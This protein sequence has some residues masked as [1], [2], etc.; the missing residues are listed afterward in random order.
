[1]LSFLNIQSGSKGNATLLYSETTLLLV[2][3]GISLCALKGGLDQINKRLVD[4]EGLLITHDHGD[5]IGGIPL[6]EG[7]V[8]L[9]SLCGNYPHLD[10]ECEHFESFVLG[11]IVVTPLKTSHDA[12]SPTGYRFSSGDTT[13][14]YMT[15][16]GYIPSITLEYMKNAD[17]YVLESN[18]DVEMLA[19]SHRP[20]CLKR[21]IASRVGHL[22]N[23][24]SAKYLCKLVGDKTKGIY[25]AHLSEETNTPETAIKTH[26]EIYRKKKIPIEG[27]SLV[28]LSQRKS[29]FGGDKR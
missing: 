10:Y 27:I 26:Q 4:I 28:A 20:E 24:Q 19:N 11:D 12:T 25:L 6:I 23:E 3:M 2:D 13:I 7:E 16:T 1:M 17:Y 21:R 5:H 22:S 9:V 18:Y 29:T 14:V 15:D 8:P